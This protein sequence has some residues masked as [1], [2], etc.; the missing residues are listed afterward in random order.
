MKPV[1]IPEMSETI[2]LHMYSYDHW[3]YWLLSFKSRRKISSTS[4]PRRIA[5]AKYRTTD[6]FC[7]AMAIFAMAAD[8]RGLQRFRRN[9]TCAIIIRAPRDIGVTSNRRRQVGAACHSQELVST[10]AKINAIMFPRRPRGSSR[11]RKLRGRRVT[12]QP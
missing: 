2:K 7:D 1:Y 9:A 8:K 5:L 10:Y 12:L 11:R 3:N 6:W 4:R